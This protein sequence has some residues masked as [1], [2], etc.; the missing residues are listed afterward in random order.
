VR[1]TPHRGRRRHHGLALEAAGRW[2]GR[3][4]RR[5][6]ASSKQASLVLERAL[7]LL[8]LLLVG[9]DELVH[10]VGVL[11]V[12]ANGY[13]DLLDRDADPLGKCVNE[14]LATLRRAVSCG[15]HLPHV[16]P[17]DHDR[18]AAHRPIA[19]DDPGMS[20]P[21]HAFPEVAL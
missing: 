20:V 10:L 19:K 16:R 21:P 6:A 17:A 14:V 12:V 2:L 8:C 11:A 4:S 18:S 15:D 9:R 5:A 13:P 3:T 7:E 1:D